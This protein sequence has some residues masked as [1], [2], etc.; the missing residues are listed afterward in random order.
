MMV[1][2]G[3]TEIFMRISDNKSIFPQLCILSSPFTAYSAFCLAPNNFSF[4]LSPKAGKEALHLVF[5]YS[6]V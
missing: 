2:S 5:V 4:K 3:L 6:E 1:V